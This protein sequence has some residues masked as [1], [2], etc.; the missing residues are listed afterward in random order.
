MRCAARF[1]ACAAE[2]AGTLVCSPSPR[3][4][5]RQETSSGHHGG[6]SR[7]RALSWKAC[8]RWKVLLERRWRHDLRRYDRSRKHGAKRFD[9]RWMREVMSNVRSMGH[10]TVRPT[11]VFPYGCPSSRTD[12]AERSPPR[13]TVADGAHADERHGM[14]LTERTVFGNHHC[15]CRFHANR[16]CCGASAYESDCGER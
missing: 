14:G 9:R 3:R 1:F 12:S 13:W 15:S 6:S 5:F 2:G 16:L 8:E 11:R 4:L 10:V 7:T